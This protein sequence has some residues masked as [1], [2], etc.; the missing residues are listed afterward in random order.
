MELTIF[1]IVQELIT[2]VIKH[3]NATEVSIH[4]TNHEDS[5]N[6]MVEDNGKGFNAS[7]VTKTNK[8]MGISSIDKRVEHLE[9]T[10]T[11]ESEK[12]QGTTIIIDI[13]L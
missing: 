8:G 9:G 5:L 1:R 6:I 12:H 2:N 3:A 10:M 7:Q 4:I 13:P 11:I